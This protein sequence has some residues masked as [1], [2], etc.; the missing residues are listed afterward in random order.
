[1]THMVTFSWHAYRSQAV[2][3]VSLAS[4]KFIPTPL[5]CYPP[6]ETENHEFRSVSSSMTCALNLIKIREALLALERGTH[7]DVRVNNNI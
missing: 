3:L 4:H 6:Q 2:A 5:S 1:M 7:M